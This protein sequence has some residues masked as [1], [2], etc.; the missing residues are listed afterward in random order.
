MLGYIYLTES[1]AI[2]ARLICDNHFGYPKENCETLHW[3]NYNYSEI[4]NYWYIIH[5]ESIN[6]LIG[7]PVQLVV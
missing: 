5:D 1:E 6:G 2:N 3:I 7:E 4:S